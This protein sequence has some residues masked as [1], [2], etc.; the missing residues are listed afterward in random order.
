MLSTLLQDV[1]P[2]SLKPYEEGL[3]LFPFYRWRLLWLGPIGN[4]LGF[5][6]LWVR[7]FCAPG[8]STVKWRE[9]HLLQSIA[10]ELTIFS[11]MSAL[12]TESTFSRCYCYDSNISAWEGA[13]RGT[14][15]QDVFL[16]LCPSDSITVWKGLERLCHHLLFLQ[17]RELRPTVDHSHPLSYQRESNAWNSYC[18]LSPTLLL[19]TWSHG[20]RLHLPIR[21]NGEIFKKKIY[22]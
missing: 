14:E 10:P 7:S 1:A 17:T 16:L 4:Q 11:I 21:M 8:P 20:P 19:W 13:E 5:V 12:S 3:P 6:W 9:Q 15:L 22:I 2:S 18:L